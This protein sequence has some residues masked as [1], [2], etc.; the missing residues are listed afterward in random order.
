M[1]HLLLILFVFLLTA[2][3]HAQEQSPPRD[4]II[5]DRFFHSVK[6]GFQHVNHSAKTLAANAKQHYHDT[7]TATNTM[8]N[9]FSL[10]VYAGSNYIADFG[11]KNFPFDTSIFQRGVT[12]VNTSSSPHISYIYQPG[13]G[14]H[15]GFTTALQITKDFSFEGGL[16]YFSRNSKYIF[17][18]DTNEINMLHAF[19]TKYLLWD[20]NYKEISYTQK[21]LEIPFYFGYTYKRFSALLGTRLILFLKDHYKSILIDNSEQYDSYYSH[22]FQEGTQVVENTIPSVKLRYV[23]HRKKIP[24]S[25]YVTA[26]WL[27]Y[28]NWDLGMGLQ[29][30]VFSM[31]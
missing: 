17:T 8:T 10:A 4:S 26:D 31:K 11:Q 29:I 19:N 27:E 1:K 5:L 3:L 7:P 2:S 9:R 25:I 21:S 6:R 12:S 16:M 18:S 15:V 13:F 24:I 22:P 20:I 30:G 28:R 23:L 14:F